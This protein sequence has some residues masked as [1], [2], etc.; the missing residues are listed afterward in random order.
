MGFY[1]HLIEYVEALSSLTKENSGL[2]LSRQLRSDA[3]VYW[4][5][6]KGVGKGYMSLVKLRKGMVMG[7][8][9]CEFKVPVQGLLEFTACPITF[10]YTMAGDYSM[11]QDPSFYSCRMGY[12]ILSCFKL[13]EL[14]VALPSREAFKN[15][16]I[17]LDPMIFFDLFPGFE[18]QLP[19][20]LDRIARGDSQSIF[21][22]EIPACVNVQMAMQDILSHPYCGPFQRIFLESKGME[23]MT[24]TLWRIRQRLLKEKKEELRPQDIE[25]VN[26]A[27]KIIDIHFCDDIKLLNLARQVGLSHSKLNLYFKVLY[28]TTVFGYVRELRIGQACF[29]LSE[30]KASVTETA[31]AVGYSSLSHFSKI[32]RKYSGQAPS[33]YMRRTAGQS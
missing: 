18:G 33:D 7:F 30:E 1:K 4:S 16:S 2:T 6:P 22:E 20:D 17:Y 14:E 12:E 19:P 24:H 5:L 23:L 29:L 32:F 11:V 10:V 13:G 8:S 15:V 25:R 31:Y 21:Y 3:E 9:E 26:N 27:K 28:G